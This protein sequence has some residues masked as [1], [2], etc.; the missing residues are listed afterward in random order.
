[1][2]R[3]TLPRPRSMLK[4]MATH[5]SLSP[6]HGP[7]LVPALR[8]SKSW[9]L[10]LRRAHVT[11]RRSCPRSVLP[12]HGASP[13]VEP[14]S[15]TG[16]SRPRSTPKNHGSSPDVEPMSWT[17]ARRLRLHAHTDSSTQNPALRFRF[18]C[19]SGLR[20][21]SRFLVLHPLSLALLTPATHPAPNTPHRTN[22]E[23]QG[24]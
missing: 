12:N 9:C 3:R 15:W 21:H 16:A 17:G 22:S 14:M 13:Y 24:H 2:D 11:D 4:T 20:L 6:C 7:A 8:A 23:S 18:D 19:N 5:P 1:M 10:T